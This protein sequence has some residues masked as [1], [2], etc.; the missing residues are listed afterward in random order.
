M[1]KSDNGSFEEY[2]Q[3]RFLSRRTNPSIHRKKRITTTVIFFINIALIAGM[4]FYLR[5]HS[6]APEYYTETLRSDGVTYRF[7]ISAGAD[8]KYIAALSVKSDAERGKAPV[9]RG[10]LARVRIY[11]E[12][13]LLL[14][15]SLA[16]DKAAV[17]LTHGKSYI[18][19]KELNI[20]AITA[21]FDDNPG[22]LPPST[23]LPIPGLSTRRVPLT[24]KIAVNGQSRIIHIRM[25]FQLEVLK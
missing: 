11:H 12:N 18:A 3:K 14:E 17:P 4:I 13:L 8:K 2:I 16:F 5:S 24:A 6:G 15:D 23:E 20:A 25:N 10:E 1:L 22:Q 21:Y 9:F 19:A 7:S